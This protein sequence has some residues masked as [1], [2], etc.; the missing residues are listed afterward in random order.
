LQFYRHQD[1]HKIE[2][3]NIPNEVFEVRYKS[4]LS[5]IKPISLSEIS[6]EGILFK[7]I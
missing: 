4:D 6:K 7:S 5:E 3:V 1:I 2:R